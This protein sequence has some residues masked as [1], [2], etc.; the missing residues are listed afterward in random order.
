MSDEN[1]EETGR[2]KKK[3]NNLYHKVC[4]AFGAELGVPVFIFCVYCHV[5]LV[6]VRA[7]SLMAAFVPVPSLDLDFL[8]LT[9]KG[10]NPGKCWATA[11]H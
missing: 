11:T 7:V 2:M 3:Q 10:W 5:H 8:E 9:K 4:F 1:S 6:T